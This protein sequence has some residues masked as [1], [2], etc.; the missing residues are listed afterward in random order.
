[1]TLAQKLQIEARETL[2]AWRIS[3]PEPHWTLLDKY[4]TDV[5]EYNKKVNITAA[6]DAATILRRHILDGMAAVGPLRQQLSNI[7]TPRLLDVGS[8]AG[9]IGFGIKL[10]WP[11]AD[12]TLMETLYRKYCF[13][14]LACA[15][16]GLKGLRVLQER[17]SNKTEGGYDAVVARALA[18]LNDAVR[19]LLPLTRIEGKTLIY[20]S[21]AV[22][23]QDIDLQ[24]ALREAQGEYQES[25]PYRLP[26]EARDRHF[27]IFRR[28][29]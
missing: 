9:F 10:A 5:L 18:P 3:F 16:I 19:L 8:G 23:P 29:A 14:N 12:V 25:I 7:E 28:N 11:D 13:L 6:Q 26:G 21:D 22:D 4:I 17:A 20:Q 1:M 15:H 27:A 2:A 24:E